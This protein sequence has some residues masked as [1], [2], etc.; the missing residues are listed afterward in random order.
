M[1]PEPHTYVT[2]PFL[3]PLDEYLPILED[4]WAKRVLTNGGPYHTQFE[5]KLAEYLGV[6][7]ISLF[8]NGTIALLAALKALDIDG[9]VITTPFSF[10]ATSHAL[11]WNNLQ[12]VFVDIDPT[13]L[14]INP[15]RIEDAI[16]PKT[17][18]ILPVHCFGRPC[19]IDSIQ[20]IADKHKLRV[21]YDA[22][23]AFGVEC[24]CGSLL[25]HGDLSVLSLHATKVFN[26]FEGGAVVSSDDA[27]KQH[28]DRLKNF[29]FA[30]ETLVDT[31]GINGK[32]NELQAGLGLVQLRYIDHVL[33]KRRLVCER[34]T[35]GIRGIQGLSPVLDN[36]S[37]KPNY[38]YYPILV[39][40]EYPISRE[41]L[42][43]ELSKK[44]IYARRYFYPLISDFPMYRELPSASRANLP[45]ATSIASKVLCLPIYPE[46]SNDEID[47]VLD[48]LHEFSL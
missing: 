3:P 11:L 27:T 32:M 25:A 41:E 10:V 1:N 9:E 22:A 46:L 33:L 44:R 23:H 17:T 16:T 4:I 47:S 30:G 7:H 20:Y 28:I 36:V 21:I 34:Y 12:P 15:S 37:L 13:S 40:S 43:D 24:D 42:Y 29:G 8:N 26:T 31:L 6:N 2:K 38:S 35:E 45:V 39:N 48:V 19:D 5:Q 18:A 14:N